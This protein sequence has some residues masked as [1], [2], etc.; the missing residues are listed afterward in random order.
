MS[1]QSKKIFF[2][3][4]VFFVDENV[5]EPA[6][7]SFLFAESLDV[8]MGE[9][10]LDVGTGCGLLGV[11]AALKGA[12]VV[13]VDVNHSALRCAQK[14]IKLYNTRNSMDLVQ[15]DLLQ[16]FRST[17]KF[18]VILFNAPYLPTED[19]EGFSLLEKAWSGGRTGRE[20]ISRFISEA[21]KYL[22]PQGRIF[23]LQ[24]TLSDID[25]TLRKFVE[26]FLQVEIVAEQALPFF[27]KIA[28]LKITFRS[29]DQDSRK[30][31]SSQ[32]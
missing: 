20:V 4:F 7:D 26:N 27:E 19:S 1:S 23:L 29:R 28:L 31:L 22:N 16:A 5:Y 13:V 25:K 12:S 11:L 9:S 32:N 21:P 3:D 6:E 18:D 17:S 15:S 8:K 24:S 10:V 14:N 2:G 30:E